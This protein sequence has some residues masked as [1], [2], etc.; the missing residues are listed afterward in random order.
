MEIEREKKRQ[1]ETSVKTL[2]IHLVSYPR[3]LQSSSR[4]LWKLQLIVYSCY[5]NQTVFSN[6][7]QI[8]IP[9]NQKRDRLIF[10][11]YASYFCHVNSEYE[12]FSHFRSGGSEDSFTV[13]NDALPSRKRIPTFRRYVP[14]SS[15][16]YSVTLEDE[17]SAFFRNVGI[18]LPSDAV[19]YPRRMDSS[20]TLL[21]QPYVYSR[22]LEVT[23]FRQTKLQAMV[24]L[25]SYVVSL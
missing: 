13:G 2:P 9:T 18:W 3:R 4:T 7:E 15:C 24:P 14:P 12:Q 25:P 10:W 19:L 23:C 1:E 21:F 11:S 8:T 6:K 17:G 16:Q 22:L 5:R 20:T